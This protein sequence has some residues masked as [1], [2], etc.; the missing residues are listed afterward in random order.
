MDPRRAD[1]IG[2]FVAETQ[3]H[4]EP[5]LDLSGEVLFSAV[6]TMRQ[7]DLYI[8]GLNPGGTGHA[9]HHHTI[10]ED[11]QMLPYKTSN[12]YLDESWRGYPR[13]TSPLQ[14]RLQWL[15]RELGYDLREVCASNLIFARSRGEDDSGYPAYA[16]IC[17]P[18][19]ER[20]LRIVRPKMLLVF[21]NEFGERARSPF[22]F[23][24]Q[25]SV[26]YSSIDS[27][28]SGH[29]NWKCRAFLTEL[30]GQPVVVV[31]LPHLSRYKVIGK[32][33]VVEWIA[34]HLSRA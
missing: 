24:H 25:H 12:N 5:L 22:Q 15:V 16:R 23:L 1:V 20:I 26:L 18:V 33:Q 10:R 11:L 3:A 34:S 32:A 4:L 6:D 29:G 28:C 2:N 31:G 21:G 13:G 8:C 17:W 19:H 14:L 27:I 9:P 30:A 7:G